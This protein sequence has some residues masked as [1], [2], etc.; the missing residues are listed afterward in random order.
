M[1]K[2]LVAAALSLLLCCQMTAFS[3]TDVDQAQKRQQEIEK[4]NSELQQSA[5]E[6]ESRISQKEQE[7]RELFSQLSEINGQIDENRRNILELEGSISDAEKNIEQKNADIEKRK[8]LL[9]QR[10]KAIY[11]AGD[12]TNIEIILGAKDFTDFL[13]KLELVSNISEHDNKLIENLKSDIG[14]L[15]KEKT[16]LS[17]NISSKEEQQKQLDENQKKY[18][19]LVAENQSQLNALNSNNQKIYD[20]L[21]ENNKELK[22]IEDEIKNY[23]QDNNAQSDDTQ[24]SQNSGD[25]TDGGSQGGS[26]INVPSGG[27]TYV[28]PTPGFYFLTSLWNED[29]GSYNHGALDIA[30]SGIAGTPVVAAASGTVAISSNTCSHNYG[31]DYSCGCGGGYG[32]YVMIDHGDGKATLYAHMSTVVVSAGDTV[33]QNQVIGYVGSTGHSTG[34]HLHFETRY[35]GEKYNPMTE[36]PNLSVSY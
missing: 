5:K 6:N 34:A 27:G 35:Y 2:K 22:S 23:Y 17:N 13:D 15:E 28:W 29:R 32:N 11:M 31:K 26:Y 1:N 14:Q 24:I 9:G 18:E 19:N 3:A 25:S 21:D 7:S 12:A 20:M 30:D 10:L 16:D 36:Y 4:A 33:S 8:E